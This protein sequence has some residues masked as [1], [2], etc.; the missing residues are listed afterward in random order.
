LKIPTYPSPGK[1]WVVIGERGPFEKGGRREKNFVLDSPHFFGGAFLK[2][3]GLN[4]HRKKWNKDTFFR[5]K[6]E[7]RT[8]RRKRVC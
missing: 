5:G 6:G 3:L 4:T 2:L 1:L 7:H 8:S